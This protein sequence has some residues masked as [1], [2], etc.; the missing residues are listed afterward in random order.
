MLIHTE[1][2]RLL[3]CQIDHLQAIVR[4]PK[5]LGGLLGVSIPD[6]WPGSHDAWPHCLEL[7]R[8]E[9]LRA[10]RGWWLYLFTH[11]H[12]RALVGCGGFKSPPVEG[13][14]ESG[15]EIAPAFRGRGLEREAVVGLVRYA[16]TR[17]EVN[18]VQALT[19]A[20]RG[21]ETDVLEQAGMRKSGDAVDAQA[22]RVLCWRVDREDFENAARRKAA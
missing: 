10:L 2:L 5:S 8:K 22:G 13:V 17:P 7:L 20:R 18:A 11:A 9:P 3:T 15:Y 6:G 12:E 19:P 14:V 1:H 21:P 4:D 16:F